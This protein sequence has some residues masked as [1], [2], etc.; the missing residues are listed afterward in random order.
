[1]KFVCSVFF[2]PLT[3][4]IRLRIFMRRMLLQVS[5]PDFGYHYLQQ[6][7]IITYILGKK[8]TM[9]EILWVMYLLS[10]NPCHNETSRYRGCLWRGTKVWHR[11]NTVHAIIYWHQIQIKQLYKRLGYSSNYSCDLIK[12]VQHSW[13]TNRYLENSYILSIC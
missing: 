2:L 13:K 5:W 7:E 8:L 12:W 9:R 3:F 10:G 4:D 1:M 11:H 6:S